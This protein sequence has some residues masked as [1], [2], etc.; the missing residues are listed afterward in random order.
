MIPFVQNHKTGKTMLIKI[1]IV[2]DVRESG[3]GE[4]HDWQERNSEKLSGVM[5]MSHNLI[6]VEVIWYK[7]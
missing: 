4:G 2:V 7:V 1:R 6:E 3:V 5:E